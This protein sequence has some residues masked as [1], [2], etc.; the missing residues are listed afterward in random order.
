MER[1]YSFEP[2]S[3]EKCRVLILGSVPGTASLRKEEYYG[4]ERNGFWKVIYSLFGEE[5]EGGYDKRKKFLLN[6]GIALWDVIKSCEREGS[7]DSHIKNPEIN[8]FESFFKKHP[9]IRNVFFNGKKAYGLF[10]KAMGF[11]FENI[12]FT[13]LKSTSPANAI[14]FEDKLG[15][16]KK[17]LSALNGESRS[18]G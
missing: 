13:C 9:N 16:W 8:D 15:D 5:Y 17:I 11:G 1:I 3:D 18:T 12:D 6:H 14:K 4:H 7:L 10:K 2:V